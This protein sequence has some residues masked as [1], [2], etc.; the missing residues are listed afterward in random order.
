MN[1]PRTAA[2]RLIE[3]AFE[4]KLEGIGSVL[5]ERIR[6]HKDSRELEQ[7]AQFNGMKFNRE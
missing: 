5:K 2:G 3:F 4:V 1:W 6:I 7:R